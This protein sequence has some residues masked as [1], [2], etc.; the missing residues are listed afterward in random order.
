MK[1]NYINYHA[2]CAKKDIF[3][4]VCEEINSVSVLIDTWWIYLGATTHI[5]VSMQGYRNYR[6]LRDGE[7]YI[8][9]G[10]DNKAEDEAIGYFRL[11]LTIDLYLNLFDTFVVSSFRRNLISISAL[12]KLGFSCSFEDEKFG[13][14]RHSNIVVS[15]FLSVMDNIYALDIIASYN[16]TLNNETQMLDKN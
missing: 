12:D 16:E 1:K 4:F 11:V 3:S 13:L 9:V 2:W 15:G 10:N 7:K 8:Y 5:S 6:K 14:Y